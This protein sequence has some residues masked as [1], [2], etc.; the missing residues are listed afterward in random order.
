[1]EESIMT[2]QSSNRLALI[3]GVLALAFAACDAPPV[4]PEL[5]AATVSTTDARLGHSNATVSIPFRA[6]MFT[7]LD[8]MIPDPLCGDFPRLLNTQV[9]EGEATHLG[10]F[11]VIITFCV[12]VTDVLDDGTLTGDESLP[13]DNG[14]G[15]LTAANGDELYIEISGAVLPSD[16][17]GYNLEFRDTFRFTGGAGRFVGATGEGMTESFVDQSADRTDHLW[18]GTLVMPVGR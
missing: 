14:F 11:S 6:D 18:L 13:Y 2:D 10:Q 9:G 5:D 7:V 1:M 8:G 3:G 12:D 15:I 17:P 4:G 16:Q